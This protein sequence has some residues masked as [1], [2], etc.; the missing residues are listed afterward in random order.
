MFIIYGKPC[1]RLGLVVHVIIKLP[2]NGSVDE[3]MFKIMQ[4]M[5]YIMYSMQIVKHFYWR[6][7]F[8]IPNKTESTKLLH[9]FRISV[10]ENNSYTEHS[11]NVD[12]FI[13]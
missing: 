1:K 8:N 3:K 12:I 6:V 2:Q 13:A 10:L 7:V 4:Y 9:V 5:L 11:H